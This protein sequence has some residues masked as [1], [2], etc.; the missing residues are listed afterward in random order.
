L[1]FVYP[2]HAQTVWNDQ[3]LL[4]PEKS[5]F[6]KTSTHADVMKFVKTLDKFS[7]EVFVFSMGTSKEGK[8]IPVVVMARPIVKTAAEALA[9]HKTIIY[10]QGNIH[11]GEVEGKEALMMLMREILIGDKNY[12]L[13]SLIILFAPI[14]NTDANDKMAK[15]LRLSQEDSP[16][17]TG[18]RESSEGY[19]LNRDGVKLDA[20]ETRSLFQQVINPWDPQ[21]FVDLHTTNGTWH[22][23]SLTWAPSPHSAGIYE[24]FQYS[25]YKMLPTIT[26][27]VWRKYHLELGPYGDYSAEEAWPPKSFYS[28]AYQ[29]RYLVN[30]FG[31]RNRMA[32]LSEAFAHERFYQRIYSTHAFITEIL[33]YTYRHGAEIKAINKAADIASMKQVNQKKGVS[34]KMIP[35][36]TLNKF[37]TYDY[38]RFNIGDTSSK[39]FRT[40]NI[41]RYNNVVYYGAYQATKESTVPS[42][43]IIPKKYIKVIENL[44]MHGVQVNPLAHNQQFSGEEFAIDSFVHEK[45]MYQ[46][47]NAAQL[48]GKFVSAKYTFNKGDVVVNMS[49]PLANLIFYMLEPESEDGL[50]HWN[51]FDDIKQSE[52]DKQWERYPVFK[53]YK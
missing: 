43:Y 22:A 17:E 35:L 4:V 49:Q 36:D 50:V 53:F 46:K 5:E 38:Q 39:L 42:G 14:Y 12:L 3:L 32:I 52:K 7:K 15:G 34:F 33:D 13:D 26:D 25:Y 16:P 27:S 23:Y 11:A 47:H 24:P 29:P 31:F 18:E 9:T 2:I 37:V 28:Y 21:I 8:E 51:F 1:V 20:I 44:K 19:D 41:V 6:L 48:Y 10:V 30:Q 45:P 40:G